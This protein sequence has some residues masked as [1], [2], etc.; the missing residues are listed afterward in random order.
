MLKQKKSEDI[1][2]Q[3]KH[4]KKT[5]YLASLRRLFSIASVL[6]GMGMCV[7]ISTVQRFFHF[8]TITHAPS[9]SHAPLLPHHHM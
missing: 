3:K 1:F 8:Y 2:T 9:P 5:L 4:Q 7:L 6:I